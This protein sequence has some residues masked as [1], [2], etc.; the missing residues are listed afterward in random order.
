MRRIVQAF[1]AALRAKETE[2][3]APGELEVRR[4][5]RGVALIMDN[6]VK[7]VSFALPKEHAIAL[8]DGLIDL[9]VDE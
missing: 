9:L 8:A 3:F 4:V 6:G 1:F 7:Q 2:E 5:G